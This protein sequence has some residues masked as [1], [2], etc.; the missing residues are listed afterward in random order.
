MSAMPS[1]E[2]LCL[3]KI[4]AKK[5]KMEEHGEPVQ[6]LVSFCPN[7]VDLALEECPTVRG[8]LVVGS[9]RL[10]R[11]AIICC[12]N[13]AR[14]VLHTDRLRTLR[15]QLHHVVFGFSASIGNTYRL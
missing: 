13:V 2:T 6:R 3:K 4:M 7:L 15:I 1:M 12:H 11:F 8:E 10:E 9:K 14:V 5:K